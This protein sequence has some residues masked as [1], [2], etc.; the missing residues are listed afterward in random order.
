MEYPSFCGNNYPGN[1]A[2]CSQP[3][4]NQAQ[5][6]SPGPFRQ[7]VFSLPETRLEAGRLVVSRHCLGAAFDQE[8]RA[9]EVL[10]LICAEIATSLKDKG[11]MAPLA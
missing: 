4:H 10:F 3:L 8:Q 5:L 2:V 1:C 6:W 9:L 7:W 11:T